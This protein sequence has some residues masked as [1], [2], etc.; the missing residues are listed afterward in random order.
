M[1]WGWRDFNWRCTY[2]RAW[3]GSSGSELF[4]KSDKLSSAIKSCKEERLQV[5][6]EMIYLKVSSIRTWIRGSVWNNDILKKVTGLDWNDDIVYKQL[7]ETEA[8]ILQ[9]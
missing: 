6:D 5:E 2:V 1:W 4:P 9:G 8:V 7:G 3:R